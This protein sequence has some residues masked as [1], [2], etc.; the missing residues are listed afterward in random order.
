MS[1]RFK[2]SKLWIARSL[3]LLVANCAILS[4]VSIPVAKADTKSSIPASVGIWKT[5]KAPF[6]YK[7]G[8]LENHV[9]GEAQAFKQYDFRECAYAEFA[10]GGKGNQFITVDVFQMGS[11]LDAFGYYAG[12]RNAHAKY[13]KIGAEAYQEKTA[14]NFWKGAYYVRI[15]ITAMNPTPAFQQALPQIAQAVAA[16]LSGSSA[17]PPML[18]MLPP[19]FSP[20]TDKYQRS[21][22]A[23]QVFLKNGVVAKYPSAGSMAELFIIQVASPAACKDAFNKYKTYLSDPKTLAVG[24]KVAPVPGIGDQAIEV[25]TKFSGEIV[26][27]VKGKYLIAIRKAKDKNA[28][29]ALVKAAVARTK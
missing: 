4:R 22:I 3:T 13:L 27:A 12:Q 19:G 24:S 5:T 21:D 9:D 10:Q 7:Q 25:K 26:A 16:K 8:D 17:T 29:A 6:I 1:F 15:A 11:P 28:A 2:V 14:L 18:N 23:G 20:K